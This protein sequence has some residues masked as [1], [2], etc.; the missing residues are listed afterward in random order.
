MTKIM[1]VVPEKNQAISELKRFLLQEEADIYVFPEGFLCNDDLQDALDI[2]R[3]YQKYVITGFKDLHKKGQHSALVIDNGEIVDKYTKCVLPSFE[4]AKGKTPGNEIR[5]VDTK[6][7]KV[8]IPI[9]Y[10]LHFPEVSRIMCLDDPVLLVNPIGSGMLHTLQWEQWTTLAKARAIENEVYVFG[11]SHFNGAIPLAYAFS[12]A[13]EC[14]LIQ[15]GEHGGF[16][17]N[18]DLA[19]SQQKEIGYREDRTP[20]L[21][22]R[23]VE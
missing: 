11:C 10:E 2:I 15:T 6:F 21:F 8:G 22:S 3:G 16:M 7:G 12:P 23:L 1:L 20:V 4:K 17:I 14:L 9:C 18:V 13:G 19:K 5:C